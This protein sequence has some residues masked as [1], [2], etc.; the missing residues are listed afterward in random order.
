MMKHIK[1]LKGNSCNKEIDLY[2]LIEQ[3]ENEQ[4]ERDREREENTIRQIEK[5]IF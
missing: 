3:C 2:E 5:Y 1:D 4:K